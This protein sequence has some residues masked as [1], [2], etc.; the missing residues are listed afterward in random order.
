MKLILILAGKRDFSPLLPEK[1]N[2]AIL[3]TLSKAWGLA[4][5]RLGMV[6]AHQDLIGYLS[7]VKYPYNL[8]SLTLDLALKSLADKGSMEQWVKQI[9]EERAHLEERLN[10]LTF[11]K[12]VYPSDANFLL[13]RMKK[14]VDV[15]DYLIKVGI[16]VRDRSSVPLC[17]GCLR[18]TVG[19]ETENRRL[20]NA[21]VAYDQSTVNPK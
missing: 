1:R 12:K 16:I 6:F 21:L 10:S 2:L 3:Q 20:Y 11:V 14:P 4:G 19:T 9:L 15:Y 13:V 18:V 17:D 7:N 5:I 8:N